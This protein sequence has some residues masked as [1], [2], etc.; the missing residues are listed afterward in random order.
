MSALCRTHRYVSK[1]ALPTVTLIVWLLVFS[2]AC[3]LRVCPPAVEEDGRHLY[4][5]ACASCHGV[6]GTGD[7]PVA[8]ELKTHTPDLTCLAREHGGRFPRDF[9]V[10]TIAGERNFAAHGTREMPVWSQHFGTGGSGAPGVASVYARRNLELLTD[11]IESIQ[12]TEK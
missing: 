8:A 9:V 4:V 2:S 12:R 10:E 11:Y 5:S 1:D 7:G 3:A 6:T